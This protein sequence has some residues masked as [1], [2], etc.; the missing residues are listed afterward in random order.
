M[1]VMGH[2]VAILAEKSR[3]EDG[4]SLDVQEE[5]EKA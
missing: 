3:L 4:K 5:I 1:S 2:V